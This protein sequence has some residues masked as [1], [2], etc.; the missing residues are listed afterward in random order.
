MVKGANQDFC[1]VGFRSLHMFFLF[2][3]YV[4]TNCELHQQLFWVKD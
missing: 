1:L 2:F 3:A 4:V